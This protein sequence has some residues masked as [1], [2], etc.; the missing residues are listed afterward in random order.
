[1][2]L[3]EHLIFWLVKPVTVLE[4]FSTDFPGCRKHYRR[5]RMKQIIFPILMLVLVIVSSA[6][7]EPLTTFKGK[8]ILKISEGGLNRITDEL[9][10]GKAADLLCV[11]SKIGEEYYWA[12]RENTPM[13]RTE[14]GAFITYFATNGI[15]YVRV[16]NPKMK[17][18]ASLMDQT[19][20]SFDYVE[21]VI[22][23][24]RSVTYYGMAE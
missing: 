22:I 7:A 4:T 24:L 15:G 20:Q 3:N 2:K 21:H 11:I 17:A 18:S 5:P 10:P 8:P 12:S 14:S 1:M 23:G 16:V 19:E 6:I 9:E 13:R